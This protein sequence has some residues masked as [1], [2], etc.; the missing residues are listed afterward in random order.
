MLVLGLGELELVSGVV[1]SCAAVSGAV[2][3]RAAAPLVGSAMLK[4]SFYM[5]SD[6]VVVSVRGGL[7]FFGRLYGCMCKKV[8]GTHQDSGRVSGGFV[9]KA[10]ATWGL[11]MW[12]G[13]ID[14]DSSCI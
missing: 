6:S 3:G 13:I 7:L 4:G 11:C 14:W 1:L 10:R 2:S 12:R 8:S 5:L 9:T